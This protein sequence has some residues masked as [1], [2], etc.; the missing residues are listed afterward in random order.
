[1]I[2]PIKTE[3][4]YDVALKKIHAYIR[5]PPVIGS[6][7][8]DEAALL[9]M[10]IESYESIHHAIPRLSPIESIKFRMEEM[11]WS[12]SELNKILGYRSR[13][14]EILSGKRKLSLT[15]IR[16]LHQVLKIPAELLIAEY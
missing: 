11:G 5:N 8:A 4:E 12:E 14:S 10:V 7:E 3:L 15:M 9:A 1:M 2:R 16:K 6:D 13:K